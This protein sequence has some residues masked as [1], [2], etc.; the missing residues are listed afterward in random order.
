[1]KIREIVEAILQKPT[2]VQPSVVRQQN[3]VGNVVA[4]IAASD[5][6][7]PASEEE[8]VLAMWRYRDLKKQA[9]KNY[10]VRLQQQLT[11]AKGVL[12]A[13]DGRGNS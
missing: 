1:M 13:R 9:D 4:Q 8:K 7:Q 12:R 10:A 3:K 2:T 5:E 6:Q 11:K